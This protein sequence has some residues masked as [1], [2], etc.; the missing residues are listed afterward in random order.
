MIG[1]GENCGFATM[2]Q[3]QAALS[4]NGGAC[5]PNPRAARTTGPSQDINIFGPGRNEQPQATRRQ[6]EERRFEQE[7]RYERERRLE[8]ERRL[9]RARLIEQE[10]GRA[11]TTQKALP[12]ATVRGTRAPT[13]ATPTAATSAPGIPLADL[14]THATPSLNADGIRRVQLA[15]KGRGFD[16]GPITGILNPRMQVAV[17]TFQTD[18][19]IEARGVLDNQTL[20]ALGEAGLAGN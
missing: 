10:R 7:R 5:V 20:L 2:G 18:Y 15:L 17:R 14:D 13:P 4:G 16:P 1:G 12:S 11:A 19:G 8:Q 6:I 3:C 9:E